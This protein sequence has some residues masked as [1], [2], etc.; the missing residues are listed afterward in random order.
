MFYEIARSEIGFLILLNF[1]IFVLDFSPLTGS[2][3]IGFFLSNL[4]SE[5]NILLNFYIIIRDL[6]IHTSIKQKKSL[7]SER[8]N[9]YSMCFQSKGVTKMLL[10]G[11]KLESL[12][13]AKWWNKL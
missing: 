11:S 7:K 1:L 5:T 13:S 4:K 6:T 3:L 8:Y 2:I 9:L 12:D 10:K